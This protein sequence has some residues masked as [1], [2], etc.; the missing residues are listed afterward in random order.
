ML[1]AVVVAGSAAGGAFYWRYWP[2]VEALREGRAVPE[3]RI[4]IERLAQE[5]RARL[6]AD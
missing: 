6:A 4:A 5:E 3:E 1:A 2:V